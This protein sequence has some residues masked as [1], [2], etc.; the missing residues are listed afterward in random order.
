[1]PQGRS[2]RFVTHNTYD[3]LGV[4]KEIEVLEPERFVKKYVNAAVQ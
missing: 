1:M 3:Y 4:A 2:P